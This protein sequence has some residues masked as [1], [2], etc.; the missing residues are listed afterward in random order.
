MLKW[1][2]VTCAVVGVLV[3]VWFNVQ[4]SDQFGDELYMSHLFPP[5]V[6]L[7][8]PVAVDAF[9]DGLAPLQATLDRKAKEPARGDEGTRGDDE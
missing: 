1:A 2:A 7:A 6:R 5:A 8:R 3:A 4:R 9:V